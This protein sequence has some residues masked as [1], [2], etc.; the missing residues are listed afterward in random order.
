MRRGHAAR[1]PAWV[2]AWM[3]GARERAG[4]AVPPEVHRL[5]RPVALG[6]SRDFAG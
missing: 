6:L 4:A 3:R 5:H 2:E 1:M